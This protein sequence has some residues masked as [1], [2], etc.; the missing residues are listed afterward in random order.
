VAVCAAAAGT[1]TAL[2]VATEHPAV[3]ALR[4]A[5]AS[6][7]TGASGVR[8]NLTMRAIA[9][10]GEAPDQP[11]ARLS[12]GLVVAEGIAIRFPSWRRPP[13]TVLAVT[14]NF[15][16]PDLLTATA[17]R[18]HDAGHPLVG[19][20][21]ADPDPRDTTS[22]RLD[23]SPPRQGARPEAETLRHLRVK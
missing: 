13:L 12:L 2:V 5:C 17:Q 21:V 10:N 6:P 15:A 16:I 7:G 23:L 14:A 11:G 1:P 3:T 9:A 19:V 22:G 18:C 20:F 4:S 8:P